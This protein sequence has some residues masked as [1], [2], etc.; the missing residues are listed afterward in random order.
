MHIVPLFSATVAK[1]QVRIEEPRQ[2]RQVVRALQSR[3]MGPGD[4]CQPSRI[5]V[6]NRQE[7]GPELIDGGRDRTLRNGKGAG[8]TEDLGKEA[9]QVA[10]MAARVSNQTVQRRPVTQ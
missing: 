1:R 9:Q 5:G 4:L 2:I 3:L 10:K 8:S 7:L 6:G